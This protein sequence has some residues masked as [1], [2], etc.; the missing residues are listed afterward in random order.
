MQR[1]AEDRSKQ[2]DETLLIH[3]FQKLRLLTVAFLKSRESTHIGRIRAK[4]NDAQP[5]RYFRELGLLLA[6]ASE[7]PRY[8]D[9][10][11]LYPPVLRYTPLYLRPTY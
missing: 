9:H 11:K 1:E 2:K 3:Y 5:N 7:I 10:I 8:D 4:F 6:F